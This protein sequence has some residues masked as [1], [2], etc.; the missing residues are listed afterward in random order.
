MTLNQLGNSDLKITPIGLGTWAIGGDLAFG[1]GPQ[2][3]AQSISAILRAVELGINWI[4]TAPVYGLGHAEKIVAKALSE[5]S[6]A[7]RPYV[8]TK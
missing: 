2:E 4:D 1:W 7:E 6:V 8:F 3:D 5:L